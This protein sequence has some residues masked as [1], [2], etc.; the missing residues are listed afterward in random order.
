MGKTSF[1]GPVYGAKSLLWAYGP[2]ACDTPSTATAT[3]TTYKVG[4]KRIVPP[5]EDWFVTEFYVDFSTCSSLGTHSLLLKSEGGS[6]TINP[7]LEAPGNGSTRAQTLATATTA[8]A[9]ST[10]DA[11][12]VTVTPDGAE[13][14]G[15]WVPAGSTLRVAYSHVGSTTAEIMTGSWQVM[16][17]IRFRSSTRAE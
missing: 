6:T 17:F 11:V 16:G 10:T 8:L 2:V 9:T 15:A 12:L 7:N 3:T 13:Y 14:E 5:Y 1:K 4:G